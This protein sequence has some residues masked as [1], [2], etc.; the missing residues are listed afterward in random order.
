MVL[1]NS[2]PGDFSQFWQFSMW[3][4]IITMKI[5]RTRNLFKRRLRCRRGPQILKSLF[6]TRRLHFFQSTNEGVWYRVKLTDASERTSY[7]PVVSQWWSSSSCLS[8]SAFASPSDRTM[9][10]ISWQLFW[11][12]TSVQW[13]K[14]QCPHSFLTLVRTSL[15]MVWIRVWKTDA[16]SR[17]PNTS[18]RSH[19][20]S[21]PTNQ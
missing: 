2:N 3:I 4:E 11:N 8:S 15:A 21:N 16:L 9:I 5:E 17:I 20:L 7:L 18:F 6:N 10:S 14:L 13:S 1:R 19:V 12:S